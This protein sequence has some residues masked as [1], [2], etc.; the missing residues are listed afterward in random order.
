[1][2]PKEF[3]QPTAKKIVLAL[4]VFSLLPIIS[5]LSMC[6]CGMGEPCS[7]PEEEKI[8]FLAA[9]LIGFKDIQF[10]STIILG[11]IGAY[12][13]SCMMAYCWE[14][15]SLETKQKF[16]ENLKISKGR[17]IISILGWIT[18]GAV[19]L[20]YLS[21]VYGGISNFPQMLMSIYNFCE[22]LGTILFPFTFVTFKIFL[23]ATLM[24]FAL[25]G[26]FIK[27]PI[28]LAGGYGLTAEYLTIPGA[29]IMFPLLIIDWYLFSCLIVYVFNKIRKK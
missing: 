27:I 25:L 18:V 16:L 2:N 28:M 14:K 21:G 23:K 8:S 6:V 7:C 13:I 11:L 10:S 15:I 17:L 29:I 9:I 4:M 5:H 26:E 19:F 22:L 20:H 1:M 3:F 24:F 12:A